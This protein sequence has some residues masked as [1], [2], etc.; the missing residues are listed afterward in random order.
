MDH[1]SYFL[2][3]MVKTLT[4]DTRKKVHEKKP[5]CHVNVILCGSRAN[6]NWYECC[7]FNYQLML[8]PFQTPAE[9]HVDHFASKCLCWSET[10]TILVCMPMMKYNVIEQVEP[11]YCLNILS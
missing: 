5:T 3:R 2:S 10:S 11:S 7:L 8:S 1:G 6:T 9:Q 4:T